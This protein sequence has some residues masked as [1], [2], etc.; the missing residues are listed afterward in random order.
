MAAASD[1]WRTRAVIRRSSWSCHT[2]PTGAFW[3]RLRAMLPAVFG[4]VELPLGEK[5][6]YLYIV[7]PETGESVLLE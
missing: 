1:A 6:E 7:D 4:G 3:P 2:S 5:A